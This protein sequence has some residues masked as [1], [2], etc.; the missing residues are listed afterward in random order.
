MRRIFGNKYFLYS[1]GV[2]IFFLIWALISLCLGNS[3]SLFPDPI[4]TIKE[5][6]LTL[7]NLYF[8]KC[9]GTTLLRMLIGFGIALIS[10]FVLGI[11]AGEFKE[12]QTV[13]S[14]I[15]TIMKSV[16]TA[17]LVFLFLV[18]LKAK[19]APILIVVLICT[20]ILYESIIGGF[21]NID[22]NILDAASIDGGKKLKTTFEVKLPQAMP[23]I[24]IGI[25]SS[26]AL[27]LKIE[28]MAEVVSGDT[29]YGL[30]VAI[31]TAMTR[32]PSNLVPIFAYAF[33]TII[34]ALL[35]TA[36]SKLVKH[37]LR[38]KVG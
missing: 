5:A 32:D 21:N 16:P 10:A 26:F 38:N 27:S 34:V 19:N 4:T 1:I 20:P 3:V 12:L 7:G 18:L 28:I 13:F 29:S 22:P 25:A 35:F 24:I 23:S 31:S 37:L 17:A 11:L 14:P 8:Y 33:L 9:L 36:L 15:M 30:G 6:F 2:L